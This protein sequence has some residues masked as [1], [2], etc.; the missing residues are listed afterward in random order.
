MNALQKDV[1]RSIGGE[2]TKRRKVRVPG[3]G[4]VGLCMKTSKAS[5]RIGVL[6][7]RKTLTPNIVNTLFTKMNI[8]L[9][10]NG[11][12]AISKSA[13]REVIGTVMQNLKQTGVEKHT[14]RLC[15]DQSRRRTSRITRS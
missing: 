6:A 9:K 15:V 12:P 3:G 14:S 5:P 10:T 1:I 4:I 7:V 8:P 11:F 13:V 2:G